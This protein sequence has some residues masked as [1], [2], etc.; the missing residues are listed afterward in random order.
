MWTIFKVFIELVT[1][2]C[3]GGGL[4]CKACGILAPCSGIKPA[5]PVLESGVLATGPPGK[6][7]HF[8]KKKKTC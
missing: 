2:L 6:S 4:G 7:L 8:L 1:I 5:S 3:F